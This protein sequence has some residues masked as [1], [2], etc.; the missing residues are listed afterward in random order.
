MSTASILYSATN[1]VCLGVS[2]IILIRLY[3]H[4]RLI[5]T[6]PSFILLALSHLFYQWP[7]AWRS[8]HYFHFLEQPWVLPLLVQSYMLCGLAYVV[9]IAHRSSRSILAHERQHAQLNPKLLLKVVIGTTFFVCIL[10][11]IYLLYVPWSQ[12][13]LYN[14]MFDPRHANSA[15]AHSLKLLAFPALGYAITIAMNAIIPCLFSLC[16][17]LLIQARG[18][19]SR[20][21]VIIILLMIVYLFL[22]SIPGARGPSAVLIATAFMTWIVH[23]NYRISIIQAFFILLCILAPVLVLTLSRQ[24][25][26]S[27]PQLSPYFLWL[28][29]R[30]VFQRALLTPLD[31]G[32][33]HIDYVQRAG[34]FFGIGAIQ[35]IAPLLHIKAINPTYIIGNHYVPHGSKLSTAPCGYLFAY[36]SYFG[37]GSL[38]FSLLSIPLLDILQLAYRYIKPELRIALIAVLSLACLRF[39]MTSY[40]EALASGGV[41]Y[42]LLCMLIINVFYS[43]RSGAHQRG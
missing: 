6:R 14:I 13:G 21:L 43:N 3:L 8:N 16:I 28:S 27:N 33:W 1:I 20:Q 15:R 9:L 37:W 2:L 38:V 4:D 41:I 24:R 26:S 10:Y 35:K 40:S 17:L 11:G 19:S 25:Y 22:V 18:Q 5:C 36:Y 34:K 29:I 42:I 7:L 12:T 32:V 31:T 39:I 23:K 30:G